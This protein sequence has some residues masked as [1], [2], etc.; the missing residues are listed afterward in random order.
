VLR[1]VYQQATAAALLQQATAVA[2]LQQAK[3]AALQRA[4]GPAPKALPGRPDLQA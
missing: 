1:C 4:L 3:A 2:L